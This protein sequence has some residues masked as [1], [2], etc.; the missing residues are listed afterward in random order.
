MGGATVRSVHANLDD[1]VVCGRSGHVHFTTGSDIIDGELVVVGA[2]WVLASHGGHV[3]AA[4]WPL[5]A[6]GRVEGGLWL[7]VLV[8]GAE[9]VELPH[10]SLNLA[11]SESTCFGAITA[12]GESV[13]LTALVHGGGL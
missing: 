9:L 8:W 13:P 4:T 2:L 6:D 7:V 10:A 3:A 5:G 11:A 12:C 1:A